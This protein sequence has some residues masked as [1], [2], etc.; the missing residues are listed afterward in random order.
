MQ[1]VQKND[2]VHE[3]SQNLPL[4]KMTMSLQILNNS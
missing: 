1:E 3:Y 2:A 4:E